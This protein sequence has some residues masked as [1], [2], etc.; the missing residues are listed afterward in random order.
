M[1]K[2]NR[3]KTRLNALLSVVIAVV[4][5]LLV[6]VANQ[7]FFKRFDLTADKRHSLRPESIEMVRELKDPVFLK[8]YLEGEFPADFKRLRDAVKQTLDE[9]RAYAGNKIQYEFVNPSASNNPVE[10][11]EMYTKLSEAGLTYTNLTFRKKDGGVEEKII[12]PGALVIYGEREIPLQ[13]LK[14]AERIPSPDLIQNSISNLEYN[15]MTAIKEVTQ[16]IKKRIAWIRGHG[17]LGGIDSYD[18]VE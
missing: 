6:N 14:S 12:F 4:I 5:L 2:G 7:F 8:V 17:E 16:P 15:L 18:I 10:R 1:V 9:L 13:I 3:N 11:K